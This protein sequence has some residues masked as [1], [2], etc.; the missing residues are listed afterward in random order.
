MPPAFGRG[1]SPGWDGTPGDLRS[2]TSPRCECSG[3]FGLEGWKKRKP[4][5]ENN[6]FFCLVGWLVGY[7]F[8]VFFS[9]VGW[10]ING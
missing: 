1:G 3:P 10:G 9:P 6:I 7:V 4:K 8:L 2:N 5:N